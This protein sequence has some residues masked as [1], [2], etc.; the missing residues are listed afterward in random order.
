MDKHPLRRRVFLKKL[1]ALGVLGFVFMSFAGQTDAN[2]TEIRYLD[3]H[4][5]LSACPMQN[6]VDAARAALEAQGIRRTLIMPTPHVNTTCDET[7]LLAEI[8]NALPLQFAFLA[9]ISLNRIIQESRDNVT[10]E[11]LAALEEAALVILRHGAVG[12]GEIAVEHFARGTPGQEYL[13]V[14]PDHPFMLRLADIAARYDVPIDIHMEVIPCV[15]VRTG[16][17]GLPRPPDLGPDNPEFLGE[18]IAAFE[19]LLKHNRKA[20]IVWSHAGW[21]NTGYRTVELMRR[22]LAG[23]RNLSMNIKLRSNLANRPLDADLKLTSEWLALIRSF[24]GRFTIGTDFKYPDDNADIFAFTRSLLN[25]LP[26]G[27]GRRVGFSNAMRIYH[28][29]QKLIC[30]KPGTSAE[31]TIW[32]DADAVAH[33]VQHGDRLGL[34]G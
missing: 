32:V 1:T 28:L 12:F 5:H 21:D 26:R 31:K 4:S 16:K 34:C 24:R 20:R 18:N 13:S 15:E 30:H 29:E 9:G 8:V 6:S 19:R 11:A 3:T 14:P 10:P 27:A 33:H 22:L 23:N 2:P 7:A 17:C 25:Q